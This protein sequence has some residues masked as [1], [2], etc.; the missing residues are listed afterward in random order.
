MLENEEVNE[1]HQKVNLLIF[2]KIDICFLL[3]FS[4]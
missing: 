3:I 4:C 2:V 1:T